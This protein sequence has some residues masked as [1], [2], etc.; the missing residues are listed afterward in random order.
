M[1]F[2]G[3]CHRCVRLAFFVL[4]WQIGSAAPS[5]DF[6]EELLLRPLP[7]GKVLAHFQFVSSIGKEPRHH[8]RLFPKAIFQIVDSLK[9]H[10]MELSFTQGRWNG[11]QWGAFDGVASTVKPGG[12]LLWSR[13][14]QSDLDVDELWRNLTNALSGLF[15]ASINFLEDPAMVDGTGKD[16]RRGALPREAVCTEN[17]TP[18]LKLLPCRD[19]AGL[20]T[21]L[22]RPRIHNGHYYSLRVHVTAG[23]GVGSLTLK[24]T[25]TVVLTTPDRRRPNW[26]LSTLFG[27]SLIGKCPVASSS[28]VQIE[29]EGSL[30]E[31]F[32]EFDVKSND[33]FQLNSPPS[34]VSKLSPYLI[35]DYDVA[36]HSKRSSLD[37]GM[38]WRAFQTW[39]PRQGPFRATQFLTGRGNGRGA[40]VFVVNA[41]HGREG[42]VDLTAF[43]IVPWYVRL[44]MHTLKVVVEGRQVKTGV[45]LKLSPADDRKSPAVLEIGV[46]IP[47]NASTVFFSVEFD[48]GYLRIDEHPPD[49]NRG[50]DVPAALFTFSGKGLQ[51]SSQVYADNLLVLLATPD[52]SMPYNVITFVMTALALFFGSLLNS[53]RKRSLSEAEAAAAPSSPPGSGIVVKVQKLLAR[54]TGRKKLKTL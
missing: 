28:R 24:Q 11:P 2:P 10:E 13:F 19:R 25:L 35:L 12:L 42:D 46:T 4:L 51:D 54:L 41:N 9:I 15:C 7:D 27:R 50:F 17:L 30:V 23:N 40:M 33:I 49:A 31:S 20:S 29:L 43:Q 26:S 45:R 48:K 21:L 16:V 44:Y 39:L 3:R 53:L 18:W 14:R 6:R 1:A 37:V 52:F 8:Q 38:S 32:E 34:K 36:S 22:D 47:R 5:E